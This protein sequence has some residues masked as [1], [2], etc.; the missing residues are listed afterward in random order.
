MVH[1][2]PSNVM[3]NPKAHGLTLVQVFYGEVRP[4]PRQGLVVVS[5]DAVTDSEGRLRYFV[6]MGADRRPIL[7]D[8]EEQY[9][10]ARVSF[11]NTRL[12]VEVACG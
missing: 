10:D 4:E 8:T 1:A 3:C 2:P 12:H 5:G 6:G 7:V 9:Q 11:D